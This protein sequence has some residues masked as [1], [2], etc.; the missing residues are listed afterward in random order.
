MWIT[1]LTISP[2]ISLMVVIGDYYTP[3]GLFLSQ[4]WYYIHVRQSEEKI[5]FFA[6]FVLWLGDLL[7]EGKLRGRL[8][9]IVDYIGCRQKVIAWHRAEL[10]RLDPMF[11][12]QQ[13]LYPS[14]NVAEGLRKMEEF[15]KGPRLVQ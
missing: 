14:N 9:Q 8:F 3:R 11:R 13:S 6:R 1:D 4:N 12:L 5:M 10:E 15:K 7:P 2:T